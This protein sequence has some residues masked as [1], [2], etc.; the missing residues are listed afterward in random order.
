MKQMSCYMVI[1]NNIIENADIL[2]MHLIY[3][4]RGYLYVC[5]YATI[6]FYESIVVILD[7]I[8]FY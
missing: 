5:I 8:Y 4:H 6:N 3:W 7:N 2:F 1:V